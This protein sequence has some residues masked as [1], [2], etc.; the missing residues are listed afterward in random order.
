MTKHQ[1]SFYKFVQDVYLNDTEGIFE[2]FIKWIT[3]IIRFLHCCK[4]GGVKG[5]KKNGFKRINDLEV[6]TDKI[7][8]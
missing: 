6:T 1:D 2:G 4:Y 7:R 5:G 3:K 8:C